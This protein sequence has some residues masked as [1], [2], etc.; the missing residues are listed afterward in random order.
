LHYW[1]GVPSADS[2]E[3]LLSHFH[4]GKEGVNSARRVLSNT[5]SEENNQNKA[6][7]R[8]VDFQWQSFST[9]SAALR[10]KVISHMF[11]NK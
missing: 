2:V 1:Q 8:T 11:L 5:F 6:L 3:K 7:W 4:D 9:L 10:S